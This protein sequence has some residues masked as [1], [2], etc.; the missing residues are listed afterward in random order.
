M[1]RRTLEDLLLEE[2]LVDDVVL[3]HARRHARKHGVSLARAVVEGGL[4]DEALAEA[5]ARRLK[6]PRIELSDEPVDDDALREVPFELAEARRLLPLSI[7]R[8]GRRRTIRVA[9]ADP[10]DLDA[11]E[12]IEMSTGCQLEAV[13]ARAGELA[14]AA[15]KHYRGVITRMIPRRP[16]FGGPG[17]SAPTTQPTH[18]IADE[19]SLELRLQALVD[20]LAE[21]GV[22]DREA[23]S[24][25]VR[26]LVKERSGE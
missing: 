3:R 12:E 6:L 9:M 11:V 21:R 25:L 8:T 23:L 5:V 26:R 4:S 24:E 13:V 14:D 10:L 16:P 2:G 18:K 1:A 19:A 7:D 15:G 20:H 17:E 22:I